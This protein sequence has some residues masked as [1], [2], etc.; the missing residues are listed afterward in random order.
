MVG[1]AYRFIRGENI[2]KKEDELSGKGFLKWENVNEEENLTGVLKKLIKAESRLL[3]DT[4]SQIFRIK[5]G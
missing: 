4:E 5:P 2:N 1:F 3:A